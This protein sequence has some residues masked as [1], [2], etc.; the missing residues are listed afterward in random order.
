MVTGLSAFDKGTLNIGGSV[1]F[2]TF[3]EHPDMDRRNTIVFSP[4]LGY[5]VWEDLS[6][7]LLLNFS[8]V[9]HGELEREEVDYGIGFR[10]FID[11]IYIGAGYMEKWTGMNNIDLISG[12]INAKLGYLLPLSDYIFLNLSA[13]YLKG[14]GDYRGD[15]S[16]NNKQEEFKFKLGIDIYLSK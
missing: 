15:M 9:Y 10:Y 7:D 8:K 6:A 11:Q 12:H 5:F 4:Q 14:I 16:G 2:D 1:S 3:K 13:D